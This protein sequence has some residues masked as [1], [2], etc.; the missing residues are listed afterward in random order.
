MLKPLL[1][2]LERFLNPRKKTPTLDGFEALEKQL[3][4]EQPK[5]RKSFEDALKKRLHQRYAELQEERENALVGNFQPFGSWMRRWTFVP[6]TLMLLVMI[7]GGGIY[8]TS[9]TPEAY[10]ES[11]A[12]LNDSVQPTLAPITIA[13]NTPMM[14][15]SVEEAFQIAPA[16]EG[17]FIWNEE[18]TT[19]YFLPETI[20]ATDTIYQ[21]VISEKA[22]SRYFKSI[23]S[24][25]ERTF[26]SQWVAFTENDMKDFI[27]Y[28]ANTEATPAFGPIMADQNE[29]PPRPVNPEL[30]IEEELSI[31]D[32]NEM[33]I[34]IK[35]VDPFKTFRTGEGSLT[36]EELAQFEAALTVME[37]KIEDRLISN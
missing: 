9:P 26:T 21:I 37:E 23:T 33:E 17:R 25:Y 27:A 36:E 24:S 35:I 30:V 4:K 11:F 15:S 7:G 34:D 29:L 6:A 1:Q 13:F 10:Y 16:I 3:K 5:P 18:G 32:E 12:T 28:N 22:K 8:M 31:D 19:L 20:F 2:I 14:E